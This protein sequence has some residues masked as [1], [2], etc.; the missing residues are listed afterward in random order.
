MEEDFFAGEA[1][2]PHDEVGLLFRTLSLCD[3]LDIVLPL[4]HLYLGAEQNL[5]APSLTMIASPS[6]VLSS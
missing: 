4:G 5:K 2:M 6:V 3:K 1:V